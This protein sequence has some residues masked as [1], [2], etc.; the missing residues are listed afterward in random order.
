MFILCMGLAYVYVYAPCACLVHLEARKGI[1]DGYGC[2]E[3]SLNPFG[4]ELLST[5][6]PALQPQCL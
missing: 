6:E 5:A 3:L 2:W 4:E 1:T